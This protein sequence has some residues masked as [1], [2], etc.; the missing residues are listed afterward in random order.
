ML[1]TATKVKAAKKVKV[2]KKKKKP[3]GFRLAIIDLGTNSVRFDVYR[4]SG[5]QAVRTYRDKTMIRLGDGVFKTGRLSP[6]GMQR[7][8]HAFLGYRKLMRELRVDQVVA[9]GTSALRSSKNASQFIKLIE[10]KSGIRVRIISGKE[11]GSLIAK[12]I[13]SNI[14]PPKGVYALVDI[15]GGST[16]VSLCRGQKILACHSLKL[17]ANRLQQMFFKTIPPT[18]KKGQLHPV[19]ALRQHLKTELLSIAKLN[20]KYDIRLAIGSSGTIRS[21][22]R[23]LKKI[24]R[25]SQV[26]NRVDLTSLTAEL[27]TM[28]RAELAAIP[29]LEPKRVDLI[30]TGAILLEEIMFALGVRYVAVTEF[31]LRDGI[32]QNELEFR[33]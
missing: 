28:T 1:G 32:L 17:G 14:V 7:A 12:G 16:E 2:R 11:E 22:S 10:S 23:I 29:G 8:V 6:Q 21:L 13:L 3:T 20:D 5:R 4:M 33:A 31:S 18:F 24:G 27:Q 15:G 25:S 30:L 26:I 9:F 19:L